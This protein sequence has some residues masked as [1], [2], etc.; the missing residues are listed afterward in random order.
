MITISMHALSEDAAV[1]KVRAAEDAWNTR[2]PK[3]VSQYFSQDGLWQDK[4][5]CLEGRSQIHAFLSAKWKRKL[6]Y[7][8]SKELWSFQK[9]R[10][11]IRFVSEW[12]TVHNKWFRS[13][14]NENCEFDGD[15][16]LK[17]RITCISDTEINEND[18]LFLLALWQTPGLA[19]QPV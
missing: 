4:T 5:E 1:A 14:G 19:P 11:S 17:K 18:R 3:I 7:R 9:N 6:H 10:F 2:C 16:L 12:R 15:G 13:C 8:H